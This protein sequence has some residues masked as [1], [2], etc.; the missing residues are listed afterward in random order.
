MML[1]RHEWSPEEQE[2]PARLSRPFS[3]IQHYGLM[4]RCI[5]VPARNITES[6]LLSV[7][8]KEYV[9]LV[10]KSAKLTTEQLYD[11][12]GQYD[13]VF[14]NSVSYNSSAIAAAHLLG[15]PPMSTFCPNP[16]EVA[17]PPPK[18][19]TFPQFKRILIV[20]WDVHQGQ[21]TQFAFYNDNRVLFISIHRYER[22]KFWPKLREGDFDFIGDGA[23]RGF[24]INVPLNKTG[25]TDC[26]FLAI[27]H[28]IIMPVAYEFDPE[29][30][31]VSCGFDAA[32][33]NAE[34]KMWISPACYGHM[35]HHLRTLAGGKIVVVLEGGYFLDSLEEGCVHVLKSLLGDAVPP[36]QA[37]GP[38]SRRP[39]VK[40]VIW[41]DINP[42]L[43][44]PLIAFSRRLLQ[45]CFPAPLPKSTLADLLVLLQVDASS[46]RNYPV[47]EF[48]VFDSTL[49][50]SFR[51]SPCSATPEFTLE[52]FSPTKSGESQ[53]TWITLPLQTSQCCQIEAVSGCAHTVANVLAIMNAIVLPMSYAFGPDLVL[54]NLGSAAEEPNKS[55]G[56]PAISLLHVAF[57]L[58]NIGSRLI[59]VTSRDA[60]PHPLLLRCLLCE[61]PPRPFEEDQKCFACPE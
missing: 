31:F 15:S 3:R 44:K 29:I 6:A 19:P 37:Q 14:F 43:P 47:N 39:L 11:L 20:D 42:K 38:P 16:S 4:E 2:C 17:V 58:K 61:A 46:Q 32:V 60:D 22:Q 54:I 24:N 59:V 48:F 56:V 36:L 13:G 35:T 21:G 33:G 1:H 34:G 25:M 49:V 28:T 5:L 45:K 52:S 55:T 23:G 9:S 18:T 27:F 40:G 7:H 10:K 30:V 41:P 12:S 50:F 53:T 51:C 8:S 26:D 57:L